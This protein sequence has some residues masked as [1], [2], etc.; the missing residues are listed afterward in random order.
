MGVSTVIYSLLS[1]WLITYQPDWKLWWTHL[2][3]TV[4]R[5]ALI[6]ITE[7]K[8]TSN[9]SACLHC[10]RLLPC[11]LITTRPLVYQSNEKQAWQK[12][13]VNESNSQLT[14]AVISFSPSVTCTLGGVSGGQGPNSA[15]FY[16]LTSRHLIIRSA[17]RLGGQLT[18]VNTEGNHLAHSLHLHSSL[19]Q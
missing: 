13:T 16:L 10:K 19:S 6:K 12:K 2:E 7:K 17:H 15:T 3:F 1:F 4:R 5:S 14:E 9:L 18:S 11:A 8:K